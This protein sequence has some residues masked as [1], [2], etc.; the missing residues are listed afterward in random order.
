YESKQKIH[1]QLDWKYWGWNLLASYNKTDFYDLFGPTKRSRAGY[2][3]GLTYGR[4]HALRKPLLYH[5]QAGVYT[6]GDL[7]VLPQYQNIATP[8]TDFQAANINGGIEKV[9]KTLGGVD[10]ERGFSW[11]VDATA[12][13]AG[14]EFYPTLQSNQSV[15]FLIPVFRNTSFWIRNSIGQ[16]FG[17]SE[18][19]MSH[20][21]FGG[22]RNNYVDWQASEQYRKPLAFPGAQIDEIKAYNYAKT[23]GEFNLRPIRLR[24]VGTGWLYPTYVKT[25]VFGTHLITDIAQSNSTRNIYNVGAQMDIQM[26]LFSYLKTTWS[27]GYAVKMEN[28]RDNKGQL[29]LSLKLLGN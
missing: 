17:N 4:K 1:A 13:Y 3:L 19:A 21:Y 18:S 28:N 24:N 7:E 27:V 8:I 11:D 10:D 29:M 20:F 22:F 25:S 2:T 5:Y 9:R 15:G 16:S 14:G 23:M 26:V 12:I 6:Y